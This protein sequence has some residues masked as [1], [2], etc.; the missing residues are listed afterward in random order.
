MKNNK[1]FTDNKELND[2]CNNLK[3]TVKNYNQLKEL[4]EFLNLNTDS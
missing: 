1:L 3:N 4:K 2:S